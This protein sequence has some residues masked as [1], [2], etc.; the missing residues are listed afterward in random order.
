MLKKWL[1][2]PV[3][4]LLVLAT[5]NC[6]GAAPADKAAKPAASAA[7][8]K[9]TPLKG[10]DQ[11]GLKG[12]VT[13]VELWGVW[14]PP[15]I[16]SMPHVQE[17]WD[18]YKSNKDFN[19]MVVNTGWRGDNLDKVKGWLAA[20]P[21]YT[22]PVFFDDRAEA[23]QF[24]VANQVNSIPRSLIYDK[25]GKLRYNDHPGGIPAGFIDGLL[26]E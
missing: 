18:K 14:C 11:A 4:A 25:K 10:F 15:C 23:Q 2:L 9:V 24:A 6:G 8:V 21:K 17:T 12:K 16:K 20:N 26:K 7:A 19:M 3:L 22:F 1:I 13:F 5:V